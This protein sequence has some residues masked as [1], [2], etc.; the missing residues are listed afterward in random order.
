MENEIPL[1]PITGWSI[2]PVKA[3]EMVTL[4]LGYITNPMQPVDSP[5]ESPH[6]V[7]TAAMAS[8]LATALQRAVQKLQDAEFQPAPGPRH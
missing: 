4:K 6:F 1:C 5:N 2:G 3:L 8:E 7:I